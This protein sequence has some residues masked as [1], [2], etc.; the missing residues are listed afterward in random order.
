M[1][2]DDPIPVDKHFSSQF[3][4][5]LVSVS[6]DTIVRWFQDRDDVLKM[7]DQSN[8]RKRKRVELRIPFSVFV[9]VYRERCKKK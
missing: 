1:K 3:Y 4:A 8:S 9:Q 6:V 7:G 5:E 2:F